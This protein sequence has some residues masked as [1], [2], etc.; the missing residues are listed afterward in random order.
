MEYREWRLEYMRIGGLEEAD[1]NNAYE[2]EIKDLYLK[3]RGER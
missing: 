2:D 1:V 3:A